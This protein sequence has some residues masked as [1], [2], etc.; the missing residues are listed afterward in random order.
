MSSHSISLVLFILIL[1][2]LIPSELGAQL[3][4]RIGLHSMVLQPG[5]FYYVTL[6]SSSND[7][8]SL[9]TFTSISWQGSCASQSGDLQTYDNYDPTHTPSVMVTPTLLPF[10]W[11]HCQETLLGKILFKKIKGWK[12]DSGLPGLLESVIVFVLPSVKEAPITVVPPSHSTFRVAP[13]SHSGSHLCVSIG[14]NLTVVPI[15][16]N[17]LPAP[18]FRDMGHIC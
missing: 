13:S 6:Y 10:C 15:S 2:L 18:K 5:P 7:P 11:V 14:R 9:E 12:W 8:L 4:G 16:I 3:R 1:L 17:L